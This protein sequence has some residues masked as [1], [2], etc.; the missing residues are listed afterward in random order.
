[1]HCKTHQHTSTLQCVLH[2][3]LQARAL[4]MHNRCSSARCAQLEDY[5]AGGRTP[6]QGHEGV[7][8][9]SWPWPWLWPSPLYGIPNAPW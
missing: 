1:M 7:P 2:E 8:D 4:H 9:G 3:A 5:A 6:L